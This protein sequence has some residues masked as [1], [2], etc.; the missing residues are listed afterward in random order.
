MCQR[1]ASA[2]LDLLASAK[3]AVAVIVVIAVACVAGTLLPQGAAAAAYVEKNPAA[4]E[5]FALFA[6]LGL[7]HVFS[8]WWFVGLLC[9]LATTVMVCSTRRFA[10]VRRVRGFAQRRALG[11]MLT[12]LSILLILS[13]AVVRGVWG[14]KGY[15]ELREGET[16]AQFEGPRGPQP[17]PFA[18]HLARFE[19][20]TDAAPAGPE[21]TPRKNPPTMVVQWTERALQA[22][23]SAEEGTVR[24]LTPEGEVPSPRNTFRIEIVKYV[25]DFAVDTTTHEVTSRSREPNN[26]A[27]LVAVNGPDYHNHRWVFAKFPDFAMHE[28][29][30]PIKTSPLRFIYHHE[31]SAAPAT[32]RGPVRNFKSTFHLIDNG[33]S[34]GTGTAAVNHPLKFKGYT[35]YQS[36]Y[37]PN[38]LSWTSLE[39]VRDPG[40]PLVYSGFLLLIGGLFV[41]FYLNPWL[42]H[43]SV[44]AGVPPAAAMEAHT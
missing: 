4:A 43:R 39:V 5:R 20:E 42:S 29:G 24:E 44:A 1:I 8:A 12:H 19:I 15:I 38:D 14:E 22:A 26:P 37:N 9:V 28:D 27:V 17:L 13:G 11:S 35:F 41:I 7:T 34:A 10:T 3:F 33:E 23:I 25:P 36:G 32:I 18:L 30:S 21:E 31:D 2:G 16:I 6:R 40:V